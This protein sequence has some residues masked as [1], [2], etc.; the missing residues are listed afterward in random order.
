MKPTKLMMAT[1]V[2]VGLSAGGFPATM[3]MECDGEIVDR[4]V[5]DVFVSQGK[6]CTLKLVIVKNG[7]VEADK[8]ESL[9]VVGSTIENGDIEAI[10]VQKEVAVIGT[11][12]ARGD[13]QVKKSNRESA[14]VQLQRNQVLN[15][16]IQVKENTDARLSGNRAPNGNIQVEKNRDALVFDNSASG[17]IQC[18]DNDTLGSGGN[19]STDGNV[20]CP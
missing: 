3:A 8:A 12:L 2:G 6:S 18:V 9:L 10:E 15:G 7:N 4:T 17:D 11:T 14:E 20:E 19:R 13:I 1:V 5:Q 16:D